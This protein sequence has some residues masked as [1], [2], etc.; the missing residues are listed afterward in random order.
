MR[1][2]QG[3]TLLELLLVLAVVG[4]IFT[5]VTPGLNRLYQRYELDITARTLAAHIRSEQA[6]ARSHQDTHEIWLNPFQ[7]RIS[8][9]EG[10]RLLQQQGFPERVQYRNGYLEQTVSRLRFNPSGTTT[11]SGRIRLTNGQGQQAE[12]IVQPVT[13]AVLYGGIR[14]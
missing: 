4:V 3:Y 11:G 10:E 13:G 12:L 8:V 14:K 7:P 5:L 2:E 6:V 9:W 1:G